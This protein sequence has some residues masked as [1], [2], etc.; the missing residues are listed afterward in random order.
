MSTCSARQR[1]VCVL[2]RIREALA[3]LGLLASPFTT[4][5]GNR[6]RWKAMVPLVAVEAVA[7][8]AK[9]AYENLCCAPPFSVA[10]KARM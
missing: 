10:L 3:C 5:L 2:E 7:C 6:W 1:W 4:S 9:V 8:V